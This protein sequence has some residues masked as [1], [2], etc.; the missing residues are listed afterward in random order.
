MAYT[1]NMSGVMMCEPSG[2][3]NMLNQYTNV[4]K[5]AEINY[6]YLIGECLLDVRG[7]TCTYSRC[8]CKTGEGRE[9]LYLRPDLGHHHCIYL[10]VYSTQYSFV[11]HN[12]FGLHFYV[13]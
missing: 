8:S 3:Y 4:S 9:D 7:W 11:M 6:L 13:F 10:T 1:P 5:L 2:L 12:R